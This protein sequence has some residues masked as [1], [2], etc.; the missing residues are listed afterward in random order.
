MIIKIVSIVAKVMFVILIVVAAL[1]TL[2]LIMTAAGLD[3]IASIAGV[4]IHGIVTPGGED[5]LMISA[6]LT[7]VSDAVLLGFAC[8]YFK[9]ELNA[10]TPF[11]HDG[12]KELFRLG[13]LNIAVPIAAGIIDAIVRVICK[14]SELPDNE[15]GSTVLMGVLFVFMALVFKYGAEILEKKD[16]E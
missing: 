3:E 8:R 4:T 12:A 5:Y 9:N 6:I 14:A 13:V 1:S 11:T 16:I 10:G 2:S 15:Y 7:C